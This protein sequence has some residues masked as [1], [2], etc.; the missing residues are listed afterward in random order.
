MIEEI[1]AVVVFGGALTLRHVRWR[2]DVL[3][4]NA[5]FAVTPVTTLFENLVLLSFRKISE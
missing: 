4:G 3:A 2:V 1:F 5:G